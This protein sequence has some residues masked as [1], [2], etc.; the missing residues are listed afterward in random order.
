MVRLDRSNEIRVNFIAKE[1]IPMGYDL[2]KMQADKYQIRCH[3]TLLSYFTI[4][5]MPRGS[6]KLTDTVAKQ[7][8]PN[9]RM[10]SELTY[11]QA[12]ENQIQFHFTVLS[13]FTMTFLPRGSVI[14]TDMVTNFLQTKY[15]H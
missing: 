10:G 15:Q 14:L 9:P 11:M 1:K 6:V 12:D 3:F 2:T 7:T 4:N 8:N 13:Y 5:M